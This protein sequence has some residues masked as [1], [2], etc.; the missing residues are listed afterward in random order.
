MLFRSDQDWRFQLGEVAGAEQ[1]ALADAAWRTLEVPHDF[2]IEGPPGADPATMEGPFDAKSPG[3]TG[4][5]ALCGNGD[6]DPV[7]GRG[8]E[9]EAH[10]LLL[11]VTV[12]E[13]M[14]EARAL[15]RRRSSPRSAARRRPA[16]GTGAGAR[17]V[18]AVLAWAQ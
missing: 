15:A 13:G 1:P 17:T 18:G 11:T 3:G 14:V 16:P 6:A 2:S 8:D 7:Q 12:E 9:V 10:G 5:G 4:A